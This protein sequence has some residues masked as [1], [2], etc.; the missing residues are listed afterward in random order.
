VKKLFTTLGVVFAV[1]LAAVIIAG[2]IF[3]PRTLRLNREGT[4]YAENA[5]SNIVEHWDSQELSNRASPELLKSTDFKEKV[6]RMFQ[7]FKT[8]AHLS[9]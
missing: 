1:I 8:R 3:I 9:F 5:V 6:D 7:M 4:T 2:A